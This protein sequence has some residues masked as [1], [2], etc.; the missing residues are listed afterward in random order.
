ME[1]QSIAL[2]ISLGFKPNILN[3]KP[4]WL[5]RLFPTFLA[6][7]FKIPLSNNDKILRSKNS[8]IIITCGRRMAGISIGLKRIYQRSYKKIFTIHIQNPKIASIYFDLLV[9]PEHD[10]LTGKNIIVSEGSL[11]S[12]DKK[13]YKNC[14]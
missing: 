12:V 9:V 4:F 6:G 5:C 11:H 13:K 2:A 10:N 7:R 8:K 14:L 1:N 3:V